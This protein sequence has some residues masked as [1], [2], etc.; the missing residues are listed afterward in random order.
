METRE[1]WFVVRALFSQGAKLAQRLRD[2]GYTVYMPTILKLERSAANMRPVPKEVPMLPSIVFL[3]TDDQKYTE[4]CH[5]FIQFFSPYYNHFD[6]EA[7]GR[8]T[9]LVVPDAQMDNFMLLTNTKNQHLMAVRREQCHF[10]GGDL[11][12]VTEGEFKGLV[13]RVARIKGQTRV[14]VELE[15]VCMVAS[16]Y[17]PGSFLEKINS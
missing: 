9:Y 13:G 7:F 16:A 2:D 6:R 14:V 11:V 15:G 5:S 8:D 4:L 10:R 17:I 12:R 1:K 3:R